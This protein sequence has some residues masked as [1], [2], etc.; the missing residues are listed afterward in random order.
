MRDAR[1]AEDALLLQNRDYASLVAAY[2]EVVRQRCRIR[3]RGEAANDV[4]QNVWLRLLSELERGK[5]YGIPFRVVLHQVVGWTIDDHF[6]GRPTHVALPDGWDAPIVEESFRE[7]EDHDRLRAL[8]DA[9]PE[10]DRAVM[11]LRYLDG[12]EIDEIAA[13]LGKTRNA[14]DQA[15]W[16]S[17][18][19]LRE[20]LRGA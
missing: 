17:H 19:K 2:H 20:M 7:I 10:V 16:R 13:R 9:L 11:E 4:A 6:A 5:T 1:D 14:V 18:G 3:V 15:L 8:F 12:L